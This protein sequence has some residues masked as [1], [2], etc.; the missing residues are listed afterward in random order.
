VAAI[1]L[2]AV[3]AFAA[4]P[5]AQPTGLNPATFARTIVGENFHSPVYDQFSFGFEREIGRDS[6]FRI[7]YV[8]TRGRDLFQT[9]DGNPRNPTNNVFI[10]TAAPGSV[11]NPCRQTTFDPTNCTLGIIRLRDNR[12]ES[13]Y[14]SMQAS[15]D[16]RLSKGFS[17]GVHFTWSSFIDT[18]SELF[19]PSGGE[20][21]VAQNSYDLAADKAR[22]SY[23][24]PLRLSGNF[25]Y[26]L[27]WY[28]QQNGFVGR[29]LGGWQ[30][31]SFFTLQSGAPFTPLNGS[32]PTGALSGIDGLVG[33]AIRANSVAPLP[34][35]SAEELFNLMHQGG[36]RFFARLTCNGALNAPATIC[37]RFGTAGRNILRADTIENVDFGI[38]K[39]TRIGE[40]TR[41]QL[42][43]DMFNATNTR[44][45]GVPTASLA[46]AAFL[47]QWTTD[48]GNRRIIVGARLVF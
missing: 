15:F 46:S 25:V 16:K 23:D 17:A 33:N 18:A 38:I 4:I 48:G 8:G 45:F 27:P 42:R 22:S 7:G 43:A 6:V 19:N 30:F 32:D 3:G 35:T 13:D 20:V 5:N 41:L 9:I 12:A 2:P 37:Q 47:N 44:N 14:H 31:N 28:Q 1:S 36:Q 21:A 10:S 39:N 24:R 29:I 11:N 26:E 34:T 40:N